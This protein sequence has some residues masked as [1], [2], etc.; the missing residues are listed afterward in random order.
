MKCKVFYRASDVTAAMEDIKFAA[1]LEA[2]K[3]RRGA[4]YAAQENISPTRRREIAQKTSEAFDK[5]FG[6]ARFDPDTAAIASV[7]HR[8]FISAA[9]DQAKKVGTDFVLKEGM[10]SRLESCIRKK[11]DTETCARSWARTARSAWQLYF[12]D[13]KDVPDAVT[14]VLSNSAV[15]DTFVSYLLD[16]IQTP[17]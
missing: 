15:R 6:S 2:N 11:K 7:W 4:R 17:P 10:L 16:L 1:V 5:A 9:N 12:P 14:D 8:L 13:S 3:A